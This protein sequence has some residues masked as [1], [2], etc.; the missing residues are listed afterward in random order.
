MKTYEAVFDESEV[1]GVFG[2]SLVQDPAME[3]TFIAL[4]KQENIIQFA[5]VDEKEYI[6][7][8][9]KGLLLLLFLPEIPEIF[10]SIKLSLL[11][12]SNVILLLILIESSNFSF[13]SSSS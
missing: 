5:A 13:L 10:L 3:S 6:L 9:S 7:F 11:I 12:S 1:D 2:I 8:F 4:N